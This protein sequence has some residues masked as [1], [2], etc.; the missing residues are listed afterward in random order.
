M[1][2]LLLAF[3]CF[4]AGVCIGFFVFALMDMTADGRSK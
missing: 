1:N 4:V 2:C 3:V